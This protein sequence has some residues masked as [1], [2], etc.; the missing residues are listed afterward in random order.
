MSSRFKEY[1]YLLNQ[2]K[3]PIS[4]EI[5]K[6]GDGTAYP[7]IGDKIKVHYTGSFTNGDKFDSSLDRGEMFEFILGA[8]QVIKGWDEGIIQMCKGETAKIT[9]PPDYAYGEYGY[10]G[11]IPPDS[12]LVFNIT[13]HEIN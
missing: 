8:G 11:V 10:P 12:T 6:E 3:M 13:L 2:A 9:C 1:I 7:Q 4:K 5:V